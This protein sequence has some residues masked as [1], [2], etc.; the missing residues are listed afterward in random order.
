MNETTAQALLEQMQ[1]WAP[2]VFA[3]ARLLSLATRIEPELLRRVR[4]KLLRGVDSG[5]EADL[6]FGPLVQSYSPLALVLA[7]EVAQL[8]RKD[9]AQNQDELD[10]AWSVLREMH[11]T[12]PPAIR[13]EE[14][15][16]WRSL[17]ALPEEK[18]PIEHLL[19]SAIRALSEDS[20]RDVARWLLRALPLLPD[21]VRIHPLSQVL[22]FGTSVRL[23]MRAP[24][25]D[26][27]ADAALH[28]WLPAILPASM[29]SDPVRIG[30]RWSA[31][32]LEFCEPD[33]SDAHVI[34][35]P[36]IEPLL[37]AVSWPDMPTTEPVLV[38]WRPGETRAV[39]VPSAARAAELET[40][41]G[42]RWRL[43]LVED[44]LLTAEARQVG[45]RLQLQVQPIDQILSLGQQTLQIQVFNPTST[46]V[47]AL[48]LRIDNTPGIAW[49]H[50]EVHQ[51]FLERDK[52]TVLRVDLEVNEAG[53]YRVTGTLRAEDLFGN[54]FSMP[55]VFQ[56]HVAQ[57][58][59][60]YRVPAYQPYV[61]GEGLHGDDP[62]FTGRT[63]LLQWLRSLWLRPRGKPAV[64]L[65]GQRRIGKTSLLNRIRRHGLADTGMLPILIN[66]Q[67]IANDYDFWQS[68]ANQMAESLGTD[69][70]HL[71]R[72]TAFPDFKT[73]LEE[74]IPQLGER[75]F[76]LMLDEAELIFDSR[77]T[78][79]LPGFLRALMQDPEYPTC[80][81]FCG[82]Y[83]LRQTSHDYAS[84]PLNMAQFRTVSYM[85]RSE[86]VEVL[87]KPSHN[88]LEFDPAVL[89][90]AYQ[91]TGGQPMLLQSLG[92]TLI[93]QFNA[94]VLNDGERSNYVTLH[95]LDQAAAEMVEQTDNAV[96]A[97][98]WY[99]SDINTHRV[100]SALAWGTSETDRQRLNLDG[101]IAA[102]EETRLSLPSA[103]PFQI[104][105]R[106]AD[107][108][109]CI[110]EGPRY[111][112]A[113]PLYRRW[114]AWRWP[115][116]RVRE[117][118]AAPV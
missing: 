104:I 76:L 107:E 77:F 99:N 98:H 69:R 81:L 86:S 66:L 31:A 83:A 21:E 35:A 96:F 24:A 32:G 4:L 49:H 91:L 27:G 116:E 62:T 103:Q 56:I 89:D 30:V 58:G 50:Q 41:L 84:A 29:R 18:A 38:R 46:P 37:I 17:S 42:D 2:G 71:S 115:P 90:T 48:R 87:E 26:P 82:S 19:L 55:F 15:L 59:H 12:A 110:R 68:I 14:E 45:V 78:E 39:A 3:L 16:T 73:F 74:L 61:M 100:L 53:D 28:Q 70:V 7:P 54:L 85:T 64:V 67:G 72:D 11:R 34:T 60:P 52:H 95:D 106:L 65:V 102:M 101:I 20:G 105:E 43:S 10:A 63:D 40:T 51:Q 5:S 57:R 92:A 23:G 113:V 8:L 114:V 79:P 44:A 1:N 22:A 33:T 109:I 6:W 118:R 25:V 97:N 36:R 93:N 117:E 111:R 13:L 9:L 80:F 75:R 112:F 88:I 94:V 108:E 47:R